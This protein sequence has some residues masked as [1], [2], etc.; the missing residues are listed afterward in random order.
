VQLELRQKAACADIKK[1]AT[2]RTAEIQDN[3]VPKFE[4]SS[5]NGDEGST[6]GFSKVQVRRWSTPHPRSASYGKE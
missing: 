5:I 6:V 3:P 2:S 1:Y 4:R